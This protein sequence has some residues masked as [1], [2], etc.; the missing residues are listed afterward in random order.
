M[1]RRYIKIT[2]YCKQTNV[3]KNFISELNQEGIIQLKIRDDDDYLD[4]EFLADLEM[5][6]RWYYDL[7]INLAGIDAMRHLLNRIEKLQEE[8]QSLKRL[9]Q[10]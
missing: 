3:E 5:F 1:E 9:N 10:I 6:S 4:E 8:I 2:E 7:G